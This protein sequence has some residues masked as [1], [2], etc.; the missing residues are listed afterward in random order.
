MVSRQMLGKVLL[1]QLKVTA[2]LIHISDNNFCAFV[3]E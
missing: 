3:G 1:W 2:L